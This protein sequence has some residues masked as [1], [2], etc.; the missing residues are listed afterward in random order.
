MFASFRLYDK[1]NYEKEQ[2]R[3]KVED[4]D[5]TADLTMFNVFFKT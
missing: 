3:N 1:E 5:F 4:L 2:K